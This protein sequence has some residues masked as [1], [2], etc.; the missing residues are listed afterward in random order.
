MA[1]ITVPGLPAKTGTILDAA[2]LH[3][4]ESS[5]DKKV[6]IAQLLAKIEA[7][8]SADIVSFLGSANKAEGRANLSIDR[9]VTVD[10][11]NYTI[12]A[13]DK[14]VAQIGTMSAAR[15]FSLPA[16][17]TVQAGAEI[18]IIDES[19]SVDSTNKIIVQRNG[20]DTID[21]QT[22]IDINKKYGQL[23]LICDGTDSW[24]IV[25]SGASIL[26]N[27]FINKNLIINGDFEI[28]QRG[29]SFTPLANDDYTLDRWQYQK[30][31]AM[32][33]D[34]SQFSDVPTVAQAGRYIPNSMS[35]DC[36]TI[37][38]S[39]AAG[40]FSYIWQKVEGYNF[41]EIAQKTFT[42]SFWVKA[43]KTGTYCIALR[44]NGFDR[45]YVA[46]YTVNA[47]NT[48]EFKTITIE[49][50]PNAGGWNYT[51]GLGI[52]IAW[53]LAAGSTFQ[54]T[55][56]SWQTGNFLATTNQ[57]N[58]CDSTSNNF[59]LA[60]VQ[61]EAGSVATE[62]EKRSI[63]KELILCQRYYEKSYDFGVN[64]GTATGNGSSG[65]TN[66]SGQGNL[67]TTF[68]S[69]KKRAA[70]SIVSYSTNTGAASKI[71]V[72][73]GSDVASSVS[74]VG[75]GAF[76]NRPTTTTTLAE[77]FYQWTANAEL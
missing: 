32:V 17:S 19:G 74:S 27:D 5:V 47:S 71:Y 7:Q 21:G 37:D 73:T 72:S 24:K 70:P 68:F 6:T 59:R 18:I 31:G 22:S 65:Y 20:T 49:A 69:V 25:S 39:I 23:E 40:E 55:A 62:F 76:H 34:L 26:Q 52:G 8:Y 63:S 16:A 30:G 53:I 77:L 35:I 46:E 41:Q 43:T 56:G 3:L 66:Q 67:H 15:T 45:S 38:S 2:Y 29:T 48:W 54:T 42:I 36:V 33:H 61:V 64:P 10:N 12:L 50:S 28:A 57:V 13:T 51:N 4:N 44:N 11:A 9:R 1:N 58:A 60:G 75:F 14:V